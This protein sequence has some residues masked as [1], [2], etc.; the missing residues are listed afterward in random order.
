MSGRLSPSAQPDDP[1][2]DCRRAPEWN[3]RAV[4]PGAPFSGGVRE[5]LP[6]A[7]RPGIDSAGANA[8]AAVDDPAWRHIS[9]GSVGRRQRTL[10]HVAPD[11]RA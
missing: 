1:S 4:A 3:V 6:D 2:V 7:E 11:C 10:G 5:T 8:R 9:V